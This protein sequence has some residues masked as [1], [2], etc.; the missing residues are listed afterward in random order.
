MTAD[1]LGND[2]AAV[3]VP[4]TG[5]LAWAPA[6]TA[7][8]TP[9]LGAALELELDPAFK[10]CGLIKTD[11]GFDWTSEASGDALDFWQDGYTL[12]SGLVDVSL[13]VTFAQT[14]ENMHALLYDV[15]LD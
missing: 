12:P 8:P 4:V 10:K 7:I 1:S 2:I 11:G 6:A 9:V 14:D 15:T 5:F 13:A 3:G